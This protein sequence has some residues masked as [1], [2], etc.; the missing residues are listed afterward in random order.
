MIQPDAAEARKTTA[1]ATSCGWPMRPSGVLAITPPGAIHQ[2]AGVQSFGFDQAGVDGIDADLPP[3][4]FLGKGSG[5]AVDGG[6]TN[7]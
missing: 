3:G 1:G 6:E 2:P 7:D 4:Q 5:Q